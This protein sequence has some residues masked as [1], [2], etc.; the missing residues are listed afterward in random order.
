V[1]LGLVL[2]LRLV[3]PAGFMPSWE[4]GRLV[5]APCPDADPAAIV[6]HA[7]HHGHGKAAKDRQPCPYA[8]AT[9][10]STIDSWLAPLLS[11]LLFGAALVVG[12]T[13]LFIQRHRQE[14]PPLR[15]PPIPA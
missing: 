3:S 6:G 4:S 11:A 15:G 1:L 7:V 12:R 8:S 2:A 5:I 10:T 14:R 9:S 13:F